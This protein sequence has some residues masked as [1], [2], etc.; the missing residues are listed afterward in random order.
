[1][2]L[3]KMKIKSIRNLPCA[4]KSRT[5]IKDL[6]RSVP[7]SSET[8]LVFL[9]QIMPLGRKVCSQEEFPIA[10]ITKNWY[11]SPKMKILIC[12]R[13]LPIASLISRL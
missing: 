12:L 8:T 2:S 3:T 10:E 5:T 13:L 6:L 4:V 11:S 1:M 9:H 7:P